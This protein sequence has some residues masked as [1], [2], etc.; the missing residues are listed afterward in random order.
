MNCHSREVVLPVKGS[1]IAIHPS[2]DIACLAPP[3]TWVT[4]NGLLLSKGIDASRFPYLT[5]ARQYERRSIY[6][7]TRLGGQ[8]VGHG[9][10]LRQRNR[11]RTRTGRR[12]GTG[13]EPPHRRRKKRQAVS[14]HRAHARSAITPQAVTTKRA[15]IVCQVPPSPWRSAPHA[16]EPPLPG[17]SRPLSRRAT[18]GPVSQTPRPFKGQSVP[19]DP[20]SRLFGSGYAVVGTARHGTARHGT[21]RHGTA[22]HGTA[23]HG[24]GR[25]DR[26]FPP[27]MLTRRARTTAA[28]GRP[29]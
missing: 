10:F 8:G 18:A 4:R 16:G 22:R 23:R 7:T 12:S 6:R 17:S 25:A 9:G 26:P 28:V 14:P 27:R 24:T 20:Q 5:S 15:G 21:A 3:S 29:S 1:D 19:G 13:E 11:S 2:L